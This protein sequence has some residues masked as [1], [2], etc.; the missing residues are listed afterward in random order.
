MSLWSAACAARTTSAAL[1]VRS[2]TKAKSRS[3]GWNAE[4]SS[5]GL[6]RAD[7]E[8]TKVGAAAIDIAL[9]RGK[10]ARNDAG[11]HVGEL[12]CDRIGKGKFRA[13]AA[14]ERCLVFGDERPGDG[15]EQGACGK[16]PF[17]FS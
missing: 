13:A 5:A 7:F 8:Q 15:F 16:R 4:S 6:D 12:G 17:G 11:A 14:K 1:T 3:T 9:R 2:S 10:K